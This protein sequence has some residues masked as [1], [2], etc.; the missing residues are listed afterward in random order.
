[1]GQRRNQKKNKISGNK[2][3]A[4]PTKLVGAAKA[5]LGGKFAVIHAYLRE[6]RKTTNNLTSRL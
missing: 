3:G 1:M 5:V 6:K 2:N 4:Q